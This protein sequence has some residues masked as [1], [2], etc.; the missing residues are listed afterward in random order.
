MHYNAYY[1]DATFDLVPAG[2]CPK[3]PIHVDGVM[4]FND[5]D[6]SQDTTGSNFV[7]GG[8]L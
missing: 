7:I 1:F 6:G 3:V 4:H 5:L 2:S 8:A